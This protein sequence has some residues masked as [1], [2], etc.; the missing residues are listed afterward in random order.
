MAICLTL[1]PSNLACIYATYPN[2]SIIMYCFLASHVCLRLNLQINDS[3][4]F[5]P[6][7][8]YVCIGYHCFKIKQTMWS[9]VSWVIL[10][11]VLIWSQLFETKWMNEILT[12]EWEREHLDMCHIKK[13]NIA[14]LHS[15]KHTRWQEKETLTSFDVFFLLYHCIDDFKL[16]PYPW[17]FQASS[18]NIF[19]ISFFML[20]YICLSWRRQTSSF[21]FLLLLHWVQDSITM[22]SQVALMFFLSFFCLHFWI[23]TKQKCWCHP[24]IIVSCHA[25]GFK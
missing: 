1:W 19:F 11:K 23:S 13:V 14:F 3:H 20:C 6:T 24:Y 7:N 8:K 10:Y 12:F 22:C 17:R 15:I 4:M 25:L 21:S 9:H 5:K 2:D 18:I 16:S